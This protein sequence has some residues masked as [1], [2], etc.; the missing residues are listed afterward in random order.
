MRI[1]GNEG[2]L[3]AGSARDRLKKTNCSWLGKSGR[4]IGANPREHQKDMWTGTMGALSSETHYTVVTIL[5]ERQRA[6]SCKG[7]GS[8][9]RALSSDGRRSSFVLENPVGEGKR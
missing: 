9:L 8:E 5:W 2:A 3:A 6:G 4:A 7:T 1:S